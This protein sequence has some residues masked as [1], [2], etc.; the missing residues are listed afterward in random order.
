MKRSSMRTLLLCFVSFA[1]AA[2]AEPVPKLGSAVEHYQASQFEEAVRE[3]EA[4]AAS[5][6]TSVEDRITARK[7]LAAS[8]LEL[9]N[10]TAARL[11]VVRLLRASPDATFE[12]DVFAPE[13]LALADEVSRE[14]AAEKARTAAAEELKLVPPTKVEPSPIVVA[15]PV[16][17]SSGMRRFAWAPATV[18]GASL[19]G[20]GVLFAMSKSVESQVRKG[21][22][23]FGE[24]DSAIARGQQQQTI[25]GVLLG[26][27]VAAGATAIIMFVSGADE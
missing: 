21:D 16:E 27:A 24:V 13:L 15:P 6:E 25:S 26:V 1:F 20:S 9:K 4:V 10:R 12:P 2:R 23:A 3:F 11:E 5:P 14:L 7:F 18:G 8:L 17:R 22:P 19:V